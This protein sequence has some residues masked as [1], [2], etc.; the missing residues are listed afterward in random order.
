MTQQGKDETTNRLNGIL[1]TIEKLAQFASSLQSLQD[2][3]HSEGTVN[4]GPNTKV[5]YRFQMRTLG[6]TKHEW[7]KSDF[8]PFQTA[9]SPTKNPRTFST[10]TAK[11]IVT[12]PETDVFIE[13]DVIVIYA[14]LPGAS[15]SSISIDAHS[16][17]LVLRAESLSCL[18]QKDLRLPAC[19]LPESL[20]KSYH[21][22]I[23]EIRLTI[24]PNS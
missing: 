13:N 12:E 4:L 18:Y 14:Q 15:D 1:N 22:G 24:Q 19:V 2:K 16:D 5:S 10:T 9:A 21:N 11:R 3:L 17:R 8:K 7:S 6:D 23:L 20:V